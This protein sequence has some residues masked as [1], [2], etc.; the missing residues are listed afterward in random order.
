MV[1]FG[2]VTR[3]GPS[4]DLKRKSFKMRRLRNRVD[5]RPCAIYRQ[6]PYN[7]WFGVISNR[8]SHRMKKLEIEVFSDETNASVVRMPERQYPGLVVQDDKLIYLNAMAKELHDAA[9]KAGDPEIRRL[10][11]NLQYEINQ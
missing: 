11:G 7:Q 3:S 6:F 8:L 10:T 2:C 5:F 4:L 9:E 1:E